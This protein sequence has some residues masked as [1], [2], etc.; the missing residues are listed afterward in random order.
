MVFL[1]LIFA[2]SNGS[3]HSPFHSE[4]LLSE[5]HLHAPGH[6]GDLACVCA[7][8]ALLHTPN[9]R[10]KPLTRNTILKPQAG[11]PLG[12]THKTTRSLGLAR[13]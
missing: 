2:V 10:I 7:L 4:F 6:E 12:H 9:I 5:L 1:K 3:P 8:L 11:G 13:A